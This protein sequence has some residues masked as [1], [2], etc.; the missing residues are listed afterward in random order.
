MTEI[1]AF[2]LGGFTHLVYSKGWLVTPAIFIV[3]TV[4]GLFGSKTEDKPK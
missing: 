4:K 2:F 1:L 3:K